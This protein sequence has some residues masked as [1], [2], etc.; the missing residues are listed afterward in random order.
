L[1][2]SLNLARVAR[3]ISVNFDAEFTK[4]RL[5]QQL[6]A[7]PPPDFKDPNNPYT[8][9]ASLPLP[10][11]ITTNYDDFMLQALLKADKD[12]KREVCRWNRLISQTESIFENGFTPTVAAPAVFHFH[13]TG[14][15]LDSLVLT[16]DDYFEFLINVSRDH[17]LIPPR[18]EKAMTGSSLL[19]LGYRLDDWDFRVMFHLLASYLEIST[20]RTHVAVQVAPVEDQA[21]AE[22]KKKAEDYLDLYFERY[23]KLDIRI[24]WGTCQEFVVDLKKR[25]DDHAKS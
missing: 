1:E 9:L 21:P 8:I 16:E 19:L 11:Y 6:Q 15:D 13:G 3:F 2:G 24:Y 23:K 17:D 14:D 4:R 18:I 20:S 5:V 7:I 25:W 10:V 12:A 22:Q